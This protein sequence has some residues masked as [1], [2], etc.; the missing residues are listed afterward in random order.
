MVRARRDEH[1]EV[2]SY[3]SA[4]LPLNLCLFFV[5]DL[6]ILLFNVFNAL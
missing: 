1:K 5:L 2:E 4:T 3:K 6:R